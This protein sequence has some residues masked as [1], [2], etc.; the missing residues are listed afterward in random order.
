MKTCVSLFARR[1]R[2]AQHT[3][4]YF[5]LGAAATGISADLSS[6]L[7]PEPDL[8]SVDETPYPPALINA[9]AGNAKSR[10]SYGKD[11][12]KGLPESNP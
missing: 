9:L 8:R 5:R 1:Q 6:T 2:Y 12:P 3:A 11:Y 7:R 4:I 10:G